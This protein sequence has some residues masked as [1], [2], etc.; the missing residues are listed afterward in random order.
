[1][2]G[3]QALAGDQPANCAPALGTAVSTTVSPGGNELPACDCVIVPGPTTLVVSE[4][5]ATNCA[6]TA[7]RVH[8]LTG[9]RKGAWSLSVTRNRR[10]T[11]KV[12]DDHEV[13]DLNSEDYH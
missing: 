5:F 12:D 6:L 8:T 9:D 2:N 10:L 13:C 7:W 1:L 4:K 3:V 11:F